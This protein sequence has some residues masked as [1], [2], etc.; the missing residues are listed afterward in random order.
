MM[1]MLHTTCLALL[2][3]IPIPQHVFYALIVS[4]TV[5]SLYPVVFTLCYL[6]YIGH[7]KLKADAG[8]TVHVSSHL[9]REAVS[10][11]LSILLS[12]SSSS[13]FLIDCW[14]FRL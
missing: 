1:L 8:E 4:F 5:G 7:L 6:A 9:R 14:K 13:A 2:G 11:M 12:T 10:K 3:V